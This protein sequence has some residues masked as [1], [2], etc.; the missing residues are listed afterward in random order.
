MDIAGGWR[1][2][3]RSVY[4]WKSVAW[5]RLADDPDRKSDDCLADILLLP[6][7]GLTLSLFLLR[8]PGVSEA[9]ASACL[10]PY[11]F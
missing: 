7:S 5:R 3:L 8:I 10:L 6:L 4:R 1:R 2:V 9:I 11:A